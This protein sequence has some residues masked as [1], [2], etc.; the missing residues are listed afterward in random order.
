MGWRP[1]APLLLTILTAIGHNECKA[2]LK[3]LKFN[4]YDHAVCIVME[5]VAKYFL[6]LSLAEDGMPPVH[7]A[8]LMERMCEQHIDLCWLFHFL[9]GFAFLYWD[10]RQAVRSNQSEAIDLIWRE[11]VP[12][13]HTDNAHKTQYAPMAILRV[14]WGKATHPALAQVDHRT[15]RSAS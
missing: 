6:A 11:C 10:M 13:M 2:D 8:S 15:A 1:Y 12:F 3:V 9:H 7:N 14:F 5:G 4:D